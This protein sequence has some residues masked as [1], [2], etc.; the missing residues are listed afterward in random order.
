MQFVKKIA[1]AVFAIVGLG[2]YLQPAGASAEFQPNRNP[3]LAVTRT[4]GSIEIDG[5]LDEPAW[6]DAAVATNFVET[7]PGDLI[8]PDVKTEVLVM[9]DADYLYL[10]FKCFDDPATVRASMRARDEIFQD[11]YVGLILDTFGD[12]AWSYEIFV[13]PLGLQGDLRMVSGSGEDLSFDMVFH[14]QGRLT[15]DG[16]VVEVAVPFSSLRFPKNSQKPWRATFWRNRPRSSRQRMSWSEVT[17]DNPCFMCQFGNLTG[18]HDVVPGSR[19]ELLPSVIASQASVLKNDDEPS[20]G[21]DNLDPDADISLNARYLLTSDLSAEATYNPDFSQVESDAAQIDVNTTS[22]L[23]FTEKR[24]FFQ[25]G[26]ELFSTW[27]DAVYTRSINDPIAAVKLNGRIGNTAL[28][29]I[30]ARDENSPL[31]IPFEES[32]G[33]INAGKSTSNIL[34]LKRQLYDDAFVGLMATDRRLDVGGSGSTFGA[35]FALRF[36]DNYRVE[37]MGMASHTN[38]PADFADSDDLEPVT[39]DN[40][41]HTAR[42][43]DES[44]WGNSFYASIEREA[45]HWS[46]DIDLRQYSPTFRADNGFIGINNRREIVIWNNLLF[47][48]NKSVVVAYGPTLSVGRVWNYDGKRKDEWVTPQFS[49][50]LPAQTSVVVEALFSRENFSGYQFDHIRHYALYMESRPAKE[51][52]FGFEAKDI[53]YIARNVD[54]PVLGDGIQLEVEVTLQPLQRL[55]IVPAW[56]YIELSYPADRGLIFAGYVSR[57]Q[58]NY[59]FSREWFARLIL[60]YDSFDREFALEP[61]LT[62]ELNPFT[63]FYL[64]STHD[65]VNIPGDT[66]WRQTERQFFAK[67]QYLFRM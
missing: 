18:I 64:G 67:F 47:N 66:T 39:F 7:Y 8:E 27:I 17:R 44:F 4:T 36:L 38:E 2:A 57:T 23:F 58:I 35:D 61:L 53:R 12:A 28:G 26:S 21:L 14:S 62:Y 11:D 59:Q 1:C 20:E 15:S 52:S 10:G 31:I 22:A 24:P 65:Y 49:L 6:R 34:R 42:F 43:D 25:E 37:F 40:G 9:Y 16:W 19:L 56:E 45:R 29:Y 3:S 5:R 41:R 55:V 51:I 63:I 30:G 54:P 46:F 50:S 60:Q 33:L 48:P 13:N 32:S